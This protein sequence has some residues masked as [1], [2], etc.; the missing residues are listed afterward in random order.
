MGDFRYDE[1]TSS[2]VAM[3]PQR[4]GAFPPSD[5]GSGLPDLVGRCPFCPGHEADTEPA[6]AQ[7]PDAGPWRVRV[8]KNL[9]PSVTLDAAAAPSTGDV[10]SLPARGQ[11]EVLV[12]TPQHDV[13]FADL[14]VS[15][16][17]EVLRM[18]RDR[19]A[20]LSKV[21][22]MRTIAA[23]RN[24]GRRAGSSQPHPHG[25]VVAVCVPAPAVERRDAAARAFAAER[26]ACL[27]SAVLERELDTGIRTVYAGDD[28]VVL[29]AHA[30]HVSYQTWVVPRDPMGSLPDLPDA[31]LQAFADCLT[32]ALR[33]LRTATRGADHNMIFR[34]PPV[35][36]GPPL[37]R[38]WYVDVLPRRGG[39]AGFELGT[40]IDVVSVLPEDAAERLRAA[41]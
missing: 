21:E 41:W 6:I 17:A 40:G 25:Q 23:F 18:Y 2:W 37:A 20:A 10:T 24:R 9:Y 34:L 29:S 22:G 8:V 33:A 36:A 35:E 4:R 1:L 19:V 31:R 16:A 39:G 30:P 26:H 12:E 13:D 7:I 15:H 11:H 32:R 27:L 14:P 3:A 5:P 28:F 38:F